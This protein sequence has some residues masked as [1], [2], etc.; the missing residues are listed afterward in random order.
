LQN[1]YKVPP[2]IVQPYVENA[3]L[4][5]LHHKM[6]RHGRLSVTVTRQEEQIVYVIEDNGVGRKGIKGDARKG[7]GGDGLQISSDRVRL[8][9][10]EE[11]ASVKI[12]DLET[13][14]IPSGTRVEV[15]LKIQ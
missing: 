11:I 7:A 13:G 9:N 10:D 12:I 15:H 14:G 4:H 2:L 6:D 1:D 5:G 3:I 8:F